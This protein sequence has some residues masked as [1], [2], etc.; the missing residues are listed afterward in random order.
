MDSAGKFVLWKSDINDYHRSRIYGYAIG[1]FTFALKKALDD[2]NNVF[3]KVEQH[4]KLKFQGDEFDF[5][6]RKEKKMNTEEV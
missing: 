3:E 5:L 1:L 6:N 2:G 4:L